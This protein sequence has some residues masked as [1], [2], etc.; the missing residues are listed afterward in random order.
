MK[1]SKKLLEEYGDAWRGPPYRTPSDNHPG[2][3]HVPEDLVIEA[4]EAARRSGSPSF[5]GKESIQ[6][7]LAVHKSRPG[8]LLATA[9]PDGEIDLEPGALRPERLPN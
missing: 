2:G 7:P 3:Q 6:Q 1:L 8:F 5:I 9:W 4:S